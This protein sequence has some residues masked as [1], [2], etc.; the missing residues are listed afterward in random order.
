MQ[1]QNAL[2]LSIAAET[3]LIYILNQLINIKFRWKACSKDNK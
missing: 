3:K 2:Y 1:M